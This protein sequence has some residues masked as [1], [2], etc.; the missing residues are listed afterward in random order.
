MWKSYLF[1]VLILILLCTHYIR[2][3]EDCS[4]IHKNTNNINSR[5]SAIV[6]LI[7]TYI[8]Q[9]QASSL[10]LEAK[11]NPEQFCT[12]KYVRTKKTSCG[13]LGNNQHDF[14]GGFIAAI[15]LNRTIVYNT[16]DCDNH[17]FFQ[18]WVM[19]VDEMLELI[20]STCV[21]MTLTNDE[22]YTIRMGED[23]I[24]FDKYAYYSDSFSELTLNFWH[25]EISPFWLYN[26]YSGARLGPAARA[27]A[28]I[29]ISNPIYIN[30]QFEIYGFAFKY[31][32]D[33]SNDVKQLCQ[34]LLSPVVSS[35]SCQYHE[36]Q[37]VIAVQMRHIETDY[38]SSTEEYDHTYEEAVEDIL[39]SMNIS[40]T[41]QC[42]LLVASDRETSLNQI[43][44]WGEKNGCR[45]IF[46]PRPKVDSEKYIA[47]CEGELQ[48]IEQG[49]H[50]RGILQLADIY[51]L[52]HAQFFVGTTS[53]TYTRL[54]ANLV[55]VSHTFNEIRSYDWLN[56]IRF[57]IH[58]PGEL[59]YAENYE[60]FI[61]L[62]K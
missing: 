13:N 36:N 35:P 52:G 54:I 27:R 4:Q 3:D 17:L 24:P 30:S 44:M 51:L 32:M 18:P 8:E 57:N 49:P 28:D 29:L 58:N 48:C 25:C 50:A 56:P 59:R 23:S 38:Y 46:V 43:S 12:R 15:I 1:S 34:P 16:L 7:E 10:R 33:F 31:L 14:L 2:S 42:V 26:K 19:N 37:L 11:N 45:T 39:H 41:K 60:R 40:Q 53:S 22:K 5:T 9:H 62:S 55:S 21:N 61:P 20:M 6:S 47:A